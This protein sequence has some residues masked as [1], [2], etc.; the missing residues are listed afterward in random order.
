MR[1]ECLLRGSERPHAHHARSEAGSPADQ[2]A[3]TRTENQS[4]RGFCLGTAQADLRG[5]LPL[6]APVAFLLTFYFFCL[7]YFYNYQQEY[8]DTTL[9]NLV[10]FGVIA[11][12]GIIAG[13]I[14]LIPWLLHL[15]ASQHQARQPQKLEEPLVHKVHTH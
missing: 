6:P 14:W 1:K 3:A 2:S 12:C 10:I 9:V 13:L 5:L 7:Y 4:R 15:R 11:C 8:P